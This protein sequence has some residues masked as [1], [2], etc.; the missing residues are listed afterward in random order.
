MAL[1]ALMSS[2]GGN[3]GCLALGSA[4]FV[5]LEVSLQSESAICRSSQPAGGLDQE[6]AHRK[7][8]LGTFVTAEDKGLLNPSKR[9]CS[10]SR[11]ETATRT[12]LSGFGTTSL[13]TTTLSI[14]TS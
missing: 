6:H 7:G 14:W 3:C 11:R 5:T 9:P 12:G 10:G 13:C 4:T 1:S 2:T 8:C